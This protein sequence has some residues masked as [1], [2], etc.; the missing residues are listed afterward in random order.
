MWVA[1]PSDR[2]ILYL[3]CDAARPESDDLGGPHQALTSPHQA[4]AA[5]WLDA[6]TG[7]GGAR[8]HPGGRLLGDHP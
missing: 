4:L 7:M 1:R 6:P 3:L 5:A 8:G 2:A